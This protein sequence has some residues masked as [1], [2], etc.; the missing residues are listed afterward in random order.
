[1]RTFRWLGPAPALVVASVSACEVLFPGTVA[2][3]DAGASSDASHGDSSIDVEEGSTR[4]DVNVG[5]TRVGDALMEADA[6]EQSDGPA[7]T[8][9]AC[10]PQ[11]IVTCPSASVLL[12]EDFENGL[13]SGTWQQQQMGGEVSIDT[14]SH[15]GNHALHSHTDGVDSGSPSLNAYIAHYFSSTLTQSI[16]V[17]AFV[18]VS[19]PVPTSNF[20]LTSAFQ[21]TTGFPGS[22]LELSNGNL[23]ELDWANNPAFTAKSPAMFPL[24][25]WV[26][27]ERQIVPGSPGQMHVWVD[28][29]EV[30]PLG[31][32][33]EVVV[34]TDAVTFGLSFDPAGPQPGFDTWIDDVLVDTQP[35]GCCK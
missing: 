1:M 25:R 28:G 4:A 7:E 18:Y 21:S 8:D 24:D 12:C 6:N 32:T 15:R 27:V 20:T 10:T 16:Y 3:E 17:R 9:A 31:T 11:Q 26:C 30:M 14:M 35:I 23:E 13:S 2:P 19:S 29:E 34:P 22:S 33:S 5:D